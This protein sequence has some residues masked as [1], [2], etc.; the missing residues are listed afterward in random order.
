[1]YASLNPGYRGASFNAQAAFNPSALTVAH[2]KTVAAA[3]LGVKIQFDE[4]HLWLNGAVFYN[5][6]NNQ[7]IVDVISTSA[8]FVQALTNLPKCKRPV[9]PSIK[10]KLMSNIWG[11]VHE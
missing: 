8:G 4:Y 1:M 2:P 5:R 7:Q 9:N 3:E 10:L 6:Y 11:A